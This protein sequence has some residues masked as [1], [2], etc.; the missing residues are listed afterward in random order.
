[1]RLIT[2]IEG[3]L[4]EDQRNNK[5]NENKNIQL[6]VNSVNTLFLK[7]L[8]FRNTKII[9][10]NKVDKISKENSFFKKLGFIELLSAGKLNIKLSK[11]K[12]DTLK[13]EFILNFIELNFCKDSFRNIIRFL[14]NTK[15]D[16]TYL[17]TFFNA[18]LDDR[19]SVVTE[20]E[21]IQDRIVN[22]NIQFLLK[23]GLNDS[24]IVYKKINYQESFKLYNLY[25]KSNQNAELNNNEI[26]LDANF[27]KRSYSSNT[28]PRKDD[29]HSDIGM[30]RY[31]EVEINM[32]NSD[33][34]YQINEGNRINEN[35]QIFFIIQSFRIYM[36]EGKDF[37][38]DDKYYDNNN[39]SADSN[40]LT[41][42]E[43][44]LIDDYFQNVTGV[45]KDSSEEMSRNR[46]IIR[47]YQSYLYFN[48]SNMEFKCF[49]F[50]LLFIN[51]EILQ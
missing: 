41:V 24:N 17:S 35:F 36:F 7:N 12:E 22:D 5:S 46:N 50:K 37:S 29:F 4:Y 13:S 44:K 14:N 21:M 20:L 40:D 25:K 39:T 34:Y 26:Y 19:E 1:M 31:N 2:E 23:P 51:L 42:N 16:I 3:I 9:L 43:F 49:Y 27:D 28:R 8:D 15:K 32:P 47:N 11:D 6:K 18:G 38:F 48:L 33:D 30:K 10:I 45:R